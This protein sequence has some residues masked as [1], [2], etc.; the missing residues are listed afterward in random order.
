MLFARAILGIAMPSNHWFSL[1]SFVTKLA[2]QTTVLRSSI[3]CVCFLLRTYEAT[4]PNLSHS[5]FDFDSTL[6]VYIPL[7]A[8]SLATFVIA[9][10]LWWHG[11]WCMGEGILSGICEHGRVLALHLRGRKPRT[12]V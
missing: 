9:R 10:R 5:P 1:Y 3:L 8:E 4:R 2:D 12:C 6:H 11:A 7:C